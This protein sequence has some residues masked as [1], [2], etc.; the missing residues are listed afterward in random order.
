M[1]V[2][3]PVDVVFKVGQRDRLV[4]V[5]GDDD[6]ELDLTARFGQVGRVG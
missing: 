4:T 5:V 1:A 2:E 6:G 3:V